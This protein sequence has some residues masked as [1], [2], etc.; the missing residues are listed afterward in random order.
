[1]VTQAFKL[2]IARYLRPEISDLEEVVHAQ[3]LRVVEGLGLKWV[4]LV[5]GYHPRA[6]FRYHGRLVE[7]VLSREDDYLMLYVFRERSRR[8]GE[9]WASVWIRFA[10]E[11]GEPETMTWDPFGLLLD[12]GKP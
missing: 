3:V 11:T 4:H 12:G 10:Y 5:P 7:L 9:E 2:A 6:V 8:S 1:M